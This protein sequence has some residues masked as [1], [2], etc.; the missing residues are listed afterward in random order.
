MEIQTSDHLID[1]PEIAHMVLVGLAQQASKMQRNCL[2]KNY[3]A[4]IHFSEIRR[5]IYEQ[6]E[7]CVENYEE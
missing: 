7:I 1:S 3:D 6:I 2:G 4:S 5:A